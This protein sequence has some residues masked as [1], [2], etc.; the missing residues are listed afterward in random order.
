[1]DDRTDPNWAAPNDSRARVSLIEAI[2][3]SG[4]QV[5]LAVTG[6]GSS[7]ISELLGVPGASRTIL[8]A[9][10]P[11]AASALADWL[12]EW[13]GQAC[14]EPTGRALAMSAWER[15][16]EL[17]PTVDPGPLVGLACTASLATDRP[18]KGSHRI[19]VA[20]QTT[21]CTY[22][23]SLPLGKGRRS[24]FQEE[25][26]ATNLLLSLLAEA[27][28]VG[29]DYRLVQELLEDG[30]ALEFYRQRARPAWSQLLLRQE[31]WVLDTPPDGHGP[32]DDVAKPKLNAPRILFPGA[33]NPPHS[34]HLQMARM[35]SVRL[36]CPV[37][38]ELSIRNV[39]KPTLDFIEIANRL[40]RLRALAEL[41]EQ[42]SDK[43]Y[44][45]GGGMAY[46]GTLLTATPT[47]LEK[48]RLFPDSLFIVGADT[49]VRIGKLRYYNQDRLQ[50]DRAMDELARM[51]CRFL[52]FGRLF[53]DTC[54]NRKPDSPP[55]MFCTLGE[56]QLPKRLL[57]LCEEVSAEEF[58][59]DLRSRD[60]RG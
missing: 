32:A 31:Q 45:E 55:A 50:R 56:L 26:L 11:Y 21:T 39:D 9:S 53:A 60:L 12:G 24:R 41:E 15:A 4:H 46:A 30:E 6:G 7:A 54:E 36:G 3:A 17:A 48:A 16:R 28:E 19:H 1:M 38:W 51:G 20:A 35:A 22:S 23:V 44:P 58:R 10:I 49:I 59:V 13:T 14:S 47:F 8:E 5:V 2:H 43:K 27:C 42:Q 57:A 52:V 18:K 40:A 25:C 34:G 29:M 33:F 37:L